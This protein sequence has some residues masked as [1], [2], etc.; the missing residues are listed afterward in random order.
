M[1]HQWCKPILFVA[2]S[3]DWR[4][5]WRIASARLAVKARSWYR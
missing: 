1:G 2:A 5:V 3:A 4:G